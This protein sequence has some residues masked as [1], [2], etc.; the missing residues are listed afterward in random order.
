MTWTPWLFL[1]NSN[2]S[3]TVVDTGNSPKKED[4]KIIKKEFIF[5]GPCTPQDTR[6]LKGYKFEMDNMVLKMFKALKFEK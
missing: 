5:M 3:S 2:V 4:I 6:K 1:Q